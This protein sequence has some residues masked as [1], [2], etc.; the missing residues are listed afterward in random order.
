MTEVPYFK[1]HETG[2][3]FP[4]EGDA[5][6]DDVETFLRSSD[7]DVNS[8]VAKENT[9]DGAKASFKLW[10]SENLKELDIDPDQTK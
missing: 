7:R 10:L 5:L 8:K 9:R 2:P 4:D 6:A 1:K 3:I